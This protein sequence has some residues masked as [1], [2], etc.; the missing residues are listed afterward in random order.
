[1]AKYE[2][3]TVPA[4]D[5]FEITPDNDN[6]LADGP[7]RG[8]AFKTA[9]DIVVIT[10]KGNTRTIPSGV[11]AVGMIHALRVKRVKAT[12]TTA[13]NIWGFV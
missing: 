12:G 8:I 4:E 5:C 6:D 2:A 10:K 7:T 1:M 9:G 13:G 3:L 11:L